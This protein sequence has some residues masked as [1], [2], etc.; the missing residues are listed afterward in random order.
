MNFFGIQ[1]FE[2][3]STNQ[4]SYQKILSG[5]ALNAL[6]QA[7]SNRDLDKVEGLIRTGVF[8]INQKDDILGNTALHYAVRNGDVAIVNALIEAKA[9]V[10]LMNNKKKRPIHLAASNADVD[11][12]NILVANMNVLEN[13]AKEGINRRDADGFAPIHHAV[14][15]Q[16]NRESLKKRI[17]EVVK[18]LLAN[19]AR[20]D[21]LHK[22]RKWT[23]LHW[24][25]YRGNIYAVKT[26]VYY[27]ANINK[28]TGKTAYGWTP[29][30][31][32]TNPVKYDDIVDF[33]EYTRDILPKTFLAVMNE[34]LSMKQKKGLGVDRN[35][36][37]NILTDAGYPKTYIK[38]VSDPTNSWESIPSLTEEQVKD[39]VSGKSSFAET[40]T[41]K[42]RKLKELT[43]RKS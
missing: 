12:V 42:K 37:I 5:G 3:T 2:P 21:H 20:V 23:P 8:D 6:Q 33:L 10:N 7:V 38:I 36:I 32:A 17:N 43:L 15:N 26:L 19:G 25:A 18:I 1:Y 14:N 35:I 28:T 27:G 24:A 16:T 29:I 30:E 39:I 9:N 34:L 4:N 22:T 41:G 11:I 13:G 31:L 40:L